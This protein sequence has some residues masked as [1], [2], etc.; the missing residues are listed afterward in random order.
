M[1][2][3]INEKQL[4][5]LQ[6]LLTSADINE[7]QKKKIRSILN[8][9]NQ[10]NQVLCGVNIDTDFQPSETPFSVA[11]VRGL[12]NK[13]NE[14]G[15]DFLYSKRGRKS[16][17]SE[18]LILFLE[19]LHLQSPPVESERW[20]SQLILD[21]INKQENLPSISLPTL[22]K[23]LSEMM[24]K[25]QDE[26]ISVL[27]TQATKKASENGYKIG[28]WMRHEKFDNV[29]YAKCKKTSE[30]CGVCYPPNNQLPLMMFGTCVSKK[31]EEN[32]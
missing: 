28:S 5:Q 15:I 24:Y 11:K 31:R 6:D 17:T 32:A 3:Q 7:T 23:I 27:I 13:F 25:N 1:K 2:L 14:Q 16:K 21:E 4:E 29:W 9:H 20:T 30:M 10:E 18:E 8:V 19:N 26:M 22:K 12:V